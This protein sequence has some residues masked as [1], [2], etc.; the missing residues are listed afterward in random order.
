MSGSG[1]WDSYSK[2]IRDM[3]RSRVKNCVMD[4][5]W[6][7]NKALIDLYQAKASN[8]KQKSINH[9]C[10]YV[11]HYV[12]LVNAIINGGLYEPL[13]FNLD[14]TSV[15]DPVD[16]VAL[17]NIAGHLSGLA[18]EFSYE[19]VPSAYLDKTEW[20]GTSDTNRMVLA[21]LNR[22]LRFV[23]SNTDLTMRELATQHID[24]FYGREPASARD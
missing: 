18:R 4:A 8:N 11:L 7:L 6:G 17:L 2:E 23:A 5:L 3:T 22:I 12:V 14:D 24:I 13:T 19:R 10:G 20:F 1:F 16:K 9:F 21:N 15:V